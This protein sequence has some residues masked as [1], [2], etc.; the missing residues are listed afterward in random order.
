MHKV[1]CLVWASLQ[2]WPLL[3]KHDLPLMEL[4]KPLLEGHRDTIRTVSDAVTSIK[5]PQNYRGKKAYIFQ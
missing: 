3:V 5:L 2:R 4:W 1:S